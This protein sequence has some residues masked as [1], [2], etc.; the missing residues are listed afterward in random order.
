M[1]QSLAAATA[2]P[3]PFSFSHTRGF[4]LKLSLYALV[5][6]LALAAA[7]PA[8][9]FEPGDTMLRFGA[10][11]IDPDV[12][13]EDVKRDGTATGGYV[14]IDEDTQL[15]L[16]A[17]YMF[18]PR[19][20]VELQTATPFESTVSASQGLANLGDVAE[21]SQLPTTLS[22]VFYLSDDPQFK[23]YVGVGYNHTKFYDE[24]GV[25]S[26][27]GERVKFED[28]TGIAIQFGADFQLDQRLFANAS[29]RWIDTET[30]AE[31][32]DTSGSSYE[33]GV[34]TDPLFYSL[35]IGYK[36]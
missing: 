24:E 34:D 31:L 7:S 22:A 20:G 2:N 23:P 35:M 8:V 11:Q 16:S 4:W 3:S 15:G 14:D 30:E 6:V 33:A 29:V 32:T 21:V 13:S 36:L 27:S 18:T 9:A 1:R 19:I 12:L 28:S 26:F 17:T 5:P 25:G 10:M